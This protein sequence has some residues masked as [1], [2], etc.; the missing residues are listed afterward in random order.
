MIHLLPAEEAEIA[1]VRAAFVENQFN[2]WFDQSAIKARLKKAYMQHQRLRCCYC[3]KYKDT[4]NNNEWDLEHILCKLWYPQFF[5]SPANLAIACKP[6]NIA[7]GEHD[8]LRPQPRPI[9]GSKPCR[10]RQRATRYPTPGWT[11]G[12]LTFGT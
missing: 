6:C 12:K 2:A 10:R 7:K 9:P 3:R 4:T 5:A 11:T 1:A 8:I